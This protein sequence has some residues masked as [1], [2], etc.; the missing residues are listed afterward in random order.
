MTPPKFFPASIRSAAAIQPKFTGVR[1]FYSERGVR[2]DRAEQV[3]YN[4]HGEPS[5]DLTRRYLG[6]NAVRRLAWRGP[7]RDYW[8]D[9]VN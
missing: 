5:F 1:V 8:D 4:R 7:G 2:C 9:R 3:C 6:P